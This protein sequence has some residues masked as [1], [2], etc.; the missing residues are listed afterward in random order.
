[1]S[2]T[3]EDLIAECKE[4]ITLKNKNRTER[5]PQVGKASYLVNKKWLKQYKKYI[6][7][8]KV[9]QSD[10]P[11]AIN[12]SDHPG[13]IDNDEQLCEIN[14]V[15]LKGTGTVDQFDKSCVDKYLKSTVHERYDYKVVN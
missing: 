2:K 15:N 11:E 10:K 1:M 12:D 6:Q 7:Y 5:N 9:K 8:K 3:L 4:F 13:P 14:E